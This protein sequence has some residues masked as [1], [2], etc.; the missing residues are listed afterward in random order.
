MEGSYALN[1]DVRAM[2]MEPWLR[3]D[4]DGD[5]VMQGGEKNPLT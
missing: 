4:D 2:A 1:C 3:G 5:A